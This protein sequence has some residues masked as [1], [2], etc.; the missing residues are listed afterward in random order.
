MARG[1]AQQENLLNTQAGTQFNNAQ[2][3]YSGVN[4]ADQGIIQNPGY[5]P[6]QQTSIT[7]S[8]MQPIA[9]QQATAQENLNR[10]AARTRNDAGIVSGQDAVARSGMQALG[11]AG[12][13][14]GTQIANDAQSQQNQALN[15]QASLYGQTTN[16]ADNLYG[17]ANQAMMAR[18]SVLQSI[19]GI[20]GAGGK[21]ATGAANVYKA[22]N[23]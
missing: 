1:A 10:T 14:V 2:S 11:Q 17:Q 9:Q 6:A 4:A 20:L 12:N 22:I 15:R 7:N 5:T 13:Q 19:T 18:P 23:G 8:T 16:S 21:A 3:L